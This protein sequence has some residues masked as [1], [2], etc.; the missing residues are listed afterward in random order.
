MINV[1]MLT[2][3]VL[4]VTNIVAIQAFHHLKEDCCNLVEVLHDAEHWGD[5]LGEYTKMEDDHNGKMQFKSSLS[6]NMIYWNNDGYWV[7][8]D[9]YEL[10][11]FYSMDDTTCPLDA[12]MWYYF[13]DDAA[14]HEDSSVDI[15]CAKSTQ[16]CCETV[17]ISRTSDSW[18]DTIGDYYRL[19]TEYNGRAQFRHS[20]NNNLLYWGSYNDW[21][22]GDNY[23]YAKLY[24]AD[25]SRCPMETQG[26][27][28]FGD[29]N[30]WHDDSS[31]EIK[32]GG[33]ETTLPDSSST[34]AIPS[35]TTS[36]EPGSC[37]EGWIDA[38]SVNLGC[39][40]VDT[41]T[42]G[43]HNISDAQLACDRVWSGSYLVEIFSAEQME[44]LKDMLV[45]IEQEV[46]GEDGVL[47]WLSLY[48]QTVGSGEWIWPI[49]GRTAEF[50][51]WA[52][53]E[54]LPQED[55]NC[56]QMLPALTNEARWWASRCYDDYNN[57][58]HVCQFMV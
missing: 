57:Q 9:D 44:F 53:G 30:Q 21:A 11:K 41:D 39:L 18:A 22:V 27:L 16:E 42:S 45:E 25:G 37:P 54:P 17:Q 32:C 52:E 50:T 19:E 36:S 43:H 1:Q 2:Y 14:W 3:C 49:S 31:V 28:Y 5:T 12:T 56:A 7:I 8:G 20:W 6:N 46:S 26:W 10:A 48:T 51:Y 4:F 40:F 55:Y 15:H 58:L 13:G 35:T 24:S 34:S 38:S 29:D 47:W 33:N 23:E